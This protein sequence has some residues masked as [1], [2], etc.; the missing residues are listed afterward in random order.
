MGVT[1]ER[2]CPKCAYKKELP[3]GTGI[4]G[5]NLK[6][7]RKIFSE[8]DLKPFEQSLQDGKVKHYVLR[9]VTGYCETCRDFYSVP[10]LT[11]KEGNRELKIK[12]KK[13]SVC[14]NVLQFSEKVHECP[15]CGA[16]LE[17][18]ETGLWD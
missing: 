14:H 16:E 4:N 15:R 18:R 13:C 3:E 10:V 9:Q 17:V 2:I 7:I 12:K 1:V 11:Y 8:E 5:R 6:L